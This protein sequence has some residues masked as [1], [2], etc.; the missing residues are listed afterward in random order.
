[1]TF[2]RLLGATLAVGLA[3]AVA[4][5]AIAQNITPGPTLASFAVRAA[6]DRAGI[7][8][9]LIEDLIL[10]C[11]YPE[12]TTGRTRRRMGE[13]RAIGMAEVEIARRT[14][15]E[16]GQHDLRHESI[17]CAVAFRFIPYL[18][19]HAPLTSDSD[20][21]CNE[22]VTRGRQWRAIPRRNGGSVTKP[23][24]IPILPGIPIPVRLSS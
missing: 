21:A 23:C 3:G 20:A 14:G 13:R 6:V 7:D 12:G 11:G 8:P 19:A 5:D 15:R 2:L 1:M 9:G 16:T 17:C 24:S 4:G 22:P 10:G 18:A